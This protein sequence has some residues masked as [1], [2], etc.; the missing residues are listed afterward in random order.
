MV[1]AGMMRGE[2]DALLQLSEKYRR[3]AEALYT[4]DEK[5]M[6]EEKQR[7]FDGFHNRDMA[8]LRVE[9]LAVILAVGICFG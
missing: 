9:A 2:G 5:N 7:M 6:T 1:P 3:L 8:E 4:A